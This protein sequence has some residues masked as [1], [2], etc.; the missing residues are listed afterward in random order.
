MDF[1]IVLNGNELQLLLEF[2]MY[3]FI[4]LF[5]TEKCCK[6]E[7]KIYEIM[8]EMSVCLL[9]FLKTVFVKDTY[10]WISFISDAFIFHTAVKLLLKWLY[11]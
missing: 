8:Q 7:W 10:I 11:S 9:C 1:A 5:V 6:Q 3:G 4:S 2:I